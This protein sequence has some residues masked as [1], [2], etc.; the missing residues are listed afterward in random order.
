MFDPVH[1]CRQRLLATATLLS[2]PRARA[3]QNVKENLVACSRPYA[4]PFS[5][6]GSTDYESRVWVLSRCIIARIQRCVDSS[7]APVS[8]FDVWEIGGVCSTAQTQAKSR[9]DVCETTDVNHHPTGPEPTEALI[10][11][12][13]PGTPHGPPFGARVAPQQSPILRTSETTFTTDRD[14]SANRRPPSEEAKT[15]FPH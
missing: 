12:I 13:G 10:E 9:T 2:V 14:R 6:F 5:D 15:G 11:H 8:C 1:R 4:I 3:P 7:F